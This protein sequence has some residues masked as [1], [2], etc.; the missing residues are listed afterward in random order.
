MSNSWLA[1]L[2]C[3]AEIDCAERVCTAS[4]QLP[5]DQMSSLVVDA[6]ELKTKRRARE[7]RRRL[8]CHNAAI[9]RAIAEN[10]RDQRMNCYILIAS[11]A[12]LASMSVYF[13]ILVVLL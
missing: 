9:Y 6:S 10:R 4:N 7:L 5:D 3:S 12:A 13:L 11:V 8:R 2:I 1:I